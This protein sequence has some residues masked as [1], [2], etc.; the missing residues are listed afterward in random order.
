MG[1]TLRLGNGILAYLPKDQI[2]DQ[3]AE[4]D[5]HER[6]AEGVIVNARVQHIRFER[7]QCV[8]S[9]RGRDVSCLVDGLVLI[10][11]YPS[12]NTARA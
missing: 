9:T 8:V 3:G 4:V 5:V 7:Y 1:A 10:G 2:S 11:V 6:I 12:I